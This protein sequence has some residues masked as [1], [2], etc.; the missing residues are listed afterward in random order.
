[1]HYGCDVSVKAYVSASFLFLFIVV[2]SLLEPSILARVFLHVLQLAFQRASCAGGLWPVRVQRA[3]HVHYGCGVSVRA[4]SCM[5]LRFGLGAGIWFALILH[6]LS[7]PRVCALACQRHG[8]V[9]LLGCY[10]GLLLVIA[11]AATHRLTLSRTFVTV[12]CVTNSL[13]VRIYY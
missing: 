4:V 3:I 10:L 9:Q 1:M 6:G 5:S 13:L 2:G 8:C 7:A 11:G 12:V